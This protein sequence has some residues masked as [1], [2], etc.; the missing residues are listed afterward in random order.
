MPRPRFTRLLASS[1]SDVWVIALAL[2]LMLPSL[3]AGLAVDDHLHRVRLGDGAP[4]EGFAPDANELFTFASGDARD[5]QALM[6]RGVFPWTTRPDL[7]LSFFRPLAVASHLVDHALWPSSPAAAHA[8]NLVWYALL[9]WVVSRLYRRV[10][11][12]P[13]IAGLS[14]L[15]Y[16]L[17]DARA[18]TVGWVANRQALISAAFGFAAVLAHHRARREHWA[19]GRWLGP[20]ALALSLAAGESGVATVG[21]LVAYALTLDGRSVPAGPAIIDDRW[22]RWRALVPYG[23]V[24]AAWAALWVALG[25]GAR[26]SG[27]Y[28]EPVRD[29]L[30]FAWALATHVPVLLAAQV[31]G[32]WSEVSAAVTGGAATALAIG[33]G[34]Y[35]LL[36]LDALKV[37]LKVSPEARFWALGAL[38]AALPIA[39]TAPADRLLTFVGVGVMGLVACFFHAPEG[40]HGV[41]SP[42]RLR[43]VSVRLW[44]GGL[45]LADLVIGPLVM[46]IRALT[47]HT[48]AA[49]VARANDS[50]PKD[51]GVAGRTIVA[52]N[53]PSDPYMAFV[54]ILRASI[55]EPLPGAQRWLAVG[56]SDVYLAREDA[57]TLRVRPEAGYLAMVSEQMVRSRSEPLALGQ[58]VVLRGV[59]VEV[60]ALTDDGRPAETRW[61]FDRPLED[62]S[63]DWVRWSDDGPGFV[64]FVPPAV[65]AQ[66]VVPAVDTLKAFLGD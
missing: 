66:V 51:P 32:L 19:P 38:G 56:Q 48:V 50:L 59:T 65:G 27:L 55:G 22:A 2:A 4:I 8:H 54:P 29:P 46:P 16:A 21:Y 1:R 35:L 26:G 53:P 28:V 10:Q 18:P 42:S 58:R 52:V 5:M 30:G 24:V 20:L 3:W 9:L 44:V 14:L 11:A 47:M 64:P 57:T 13:W 60:T 34:V 15:L 33:C 23:L 62:P 43:R 39:G 45:V 61:R 6:D 17:D 41:V 63:F 37:V 25:Y 7:R 31:S 36:F 12:L 49:S 40:E